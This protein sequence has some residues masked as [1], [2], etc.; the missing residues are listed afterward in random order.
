MSRATDWDDGLAEAIA[1]FKKTR[2][3]QP[4]VKVTLE[5][6]GEEP[7]L[8]QAQPGP[9]DDLVS[10]SVYPAGREREMIYN[11]AEDR[12]YTPRVVVIHPARII[13][14]ELVREAPNVVSFGFQPSPNERAESAS[15]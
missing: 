10:L 7:Y 15:S 14:I 6:T 1:D 3:S 2:G 9:G 5:A 8:H 11:E 12:D 4:V 13:K